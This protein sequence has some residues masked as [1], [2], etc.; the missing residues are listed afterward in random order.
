MTV[1]A[2]AISPVSHAQFLVHRKL[3]ECPALIEN[4]IR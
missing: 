3:E 4:L 1:M 2:I